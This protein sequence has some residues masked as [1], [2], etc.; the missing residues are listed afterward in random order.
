MELMVLFDRCL[1]CGICENLAPEVIRVED[2]AQV[3]LKQVPEKFQKAVQQAVNE[4]P[5]EALKI[6]E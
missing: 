4:C 6:K 2:V 3:I 5:E 1:G